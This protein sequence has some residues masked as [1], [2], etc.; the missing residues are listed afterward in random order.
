MSLLTDVQRVRMLDNGAARVRGEG[1]DP[2]PVVKIYTPDFRAV[3]L[4]TELDPLDGDTA[5][6]LCDAGIGWP[7]LSAVSIRY[8]ESMKG[9]RGYS[10]ACDSSFEA[11][12]A[13]SEYLSAARARGT[14]ME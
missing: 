10:L 2:S 3:W 12:F 14:A 13:L 1:R 5:Y 8:L 9:P 6:G 11:K 7:E 4:L